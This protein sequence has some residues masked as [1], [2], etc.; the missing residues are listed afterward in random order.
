[1]ALRHAFS[2]FNTTQMSTLFGPLSSNIIRS[3]VDNF[4]VN[5]GTTGSDRICGQIQNGYINLLNLDDIDHITLCRLGWDLGVRS[6]GGYHDNMNEP[7]MVFSLYIED[8]LDDKEY[9]Y[10]HIRNRLRGSDF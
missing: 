9:L 2:R 8:M 10:Q 6:P 1:M 4:V 7:E 3:R 5:P